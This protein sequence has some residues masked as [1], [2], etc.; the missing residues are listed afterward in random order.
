VKPHVVVVGP[1]AMLG[2]AERSLLELLGRWQ[3]AVRVTLIVPEAGPLVA[4]ARAAGADVLVRPWPAALLDLGERA[5]GRPALGA[6][7]RA[8][9]TTPSTVWRLRRT[10]AGLAPDV[11]VS[12]GIKAHVLAALAR[13]DGDAP[14]V[15]YGRE[16]LSDRGLSRRLLRAVSRRCGRAIAIS[17]FVASELRTV[18]PARVPIDVVYNIVDLARFRPGTPAAADLTKAPGAVW[19]AVLG[20]LTPLKGQDLFL[21][22]AAVVAADLPAARFLVVG[23]GGYRTEAGLGFAAHLRAEAARLGIAERVDFL[24]ARD[25]VPQVLAAV[26][27]LVQPNRGPEGLGRSVLEAMASAVPVIAVDR[28]GPAEIVR[29]GETG[30][31][32]R[33]GDVAALAA[34]MRRLGDDA[35]SR[36][37]LGRAARAWVERSLDGE[38]LADAARRAVLGGGSA[39]QPAPAIR[40]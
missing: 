40:R 18:L 12:N 28:W 15:W 31:L 37:R 10:L 34:A 9:L 8:A 14:L 13:R 5:R 1:T 2:G 24:G 16:A 38:R 29:D 7:L 11:V 19:F 39:I 17:H 32:V 3:D 26:D 33:C 20:A 4:A 25:D 6:V 36:G 23:A 35:E 22:A 27:V 30:V 21:Q